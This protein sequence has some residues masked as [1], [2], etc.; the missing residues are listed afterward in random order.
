MRM[1]GN[2]LDETALVNA[3]I[4]P[5]LMLDADSTVGIIRPNMTFSDKMTADIAGIKFTLVHAPGETPDQIFVWLPKKRVLLCGD[6]IYKTFPN[7]YTIRGTAYRDVMQWV[8]SIDMMRDLEPDFLVP[9]HTGPVAGR[10]KI[11]KIL[12]D[13][14][15]AIQYVH[16]QTI[17]KM[18]M[19]MT[20][21]EIAAS[22]HLPRHLAASPYLQE[23]YGT[24]PW[25]ARAI[26][27]GYLGWFD[28]D[29]AH[30]FPLPPLE[31]AK[32]L[33]GIAGG[34]DRLRDAARRALD[35][36]D[37]QWALEL[38][39]KIL[40]L[41]PK[42]EI[43][44]DIRVQALTRLGESAPNPNARHYY[45]TCA[46]EL[47]QGLVIKEEAKPTPEMVHAIPMDRFFNAL[48]VNLD[49]EKCKDIVMTVVFVFPD[50]GEAYTIHLRRG[51]AEIRP[52]L[53]P[54]PDITVKID[55]D[56]W[57]E[58]LAKMRNPLIT[59]TTH[60]DVKGGRIKFLKFLSYFMPVEKE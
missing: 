51:V 42:D 40:L 27:C 60:A 17:R 38:S 11:R 41:D 34:I 22:I 4:G 3:G 46:A 28:G 33:S 20:P 6:N 56:I 39:G 57:K 50:T 2:Y 10:R 23:Y 26:F 5:R 18:N 37:L 45:L 47:G 32:R 30:L 31:S 49:P 55:S 58:M 54:K 14:R 29:P 43:A 15:D 12:T 16:D 35:S 53:D 44:K 36:G 8:H 59:I 52:R 25:S 9:G 21:D 13:Y 24:V 7:L 48:A 19:D 1:F